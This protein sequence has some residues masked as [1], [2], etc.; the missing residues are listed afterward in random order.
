MPIESWKFE[1]HLITGSYDN[2]IPYGDMQ[3]ISFGALWTGFY[4]Y[5][6]GGIPWSFKAH[7][8]QCTIQS[9]VVNP[10]FFNLLADFAISHPG[11]YHL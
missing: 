2:E 7:Y 1:S 8:V 5:G 3:S 6:P 10:N 4:N 11:H 9:R